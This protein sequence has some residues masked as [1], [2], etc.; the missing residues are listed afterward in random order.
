MVG[1]FE[2]ALFA[3]KAGEISAPVKTD[4]GWHVI[5]L[6]EVKSGSRQTF[7][8]VREALAREQARPIASARSTNFSRAGRPGPQEPVL[9]GSGRARNEP[10]G[11]E[12]GT[13]RA[14]ANA[15]ASCR[16]GGVAR[17]RFDETLIQ[18]GTVSDPI[19]MRPATAC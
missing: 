18:D 2:S 9:A 10:A 4:F 14:H 7:E 17:R 11:A 16:S 15:Q 8:Q 6:R 1:P 13:V 12:A 3:M 5:Q 19:E